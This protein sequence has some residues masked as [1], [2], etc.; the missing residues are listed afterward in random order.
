MDSTSPAVREYGEHHK[1]SRFVPEG[2][3]DY[4]LRRWTRIVAYVE[5]GYHAIPS[6]LR[7]K[8]RPVSE[9]DRSVRTVEQG[10]IGR[11]RRCICPQGRQTSDKD[12]GKTL[13]RQSQGCVATG[14]LQSAAYRD[15]HFA[16]P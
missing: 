14:A 16:L 11:I 15:R 2:E 12:L 5:D 8:D 6:A 3:F 10:Y 13:S 7:G 9:S 4:L 1:F